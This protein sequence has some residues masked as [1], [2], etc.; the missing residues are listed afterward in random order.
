[1]FKTPPPLNVEAPDVPVVVKLV[2]RPPPPG[3]APHSILPEAS[4]C[5]YSLPVF[6][7]VVKKP[8]PVLV[9]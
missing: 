1:M 7:S 3:A 2:T 5:K 8:K 9:F 4:V 6:V